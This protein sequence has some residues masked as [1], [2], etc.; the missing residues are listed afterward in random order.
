M[1]EIRVR[2]LDFQRRWYCSQVVRKVSTEGLVRCTA[3]I[4]G[5]RYF[6]GCA[7]VAP[8]G[9]R[10]GGESATV[11][12]GGPGRLQAVRGLEKTVNRQNYTDVAGDCVGWSAAKSA[13]DQPGR[14][15]PCSP[16]KR[17]VAGSRASA[18]RLPHGIIVDLKVPRRVPAR[19][20]QS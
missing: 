1:I 11:A 16:D 18:R 12:A 15:G 5:F 2:L 9:Q 17:D 7:S 8:P 20:R 13:P 3:E 14:N 4:L 10:H 6:S 19:T